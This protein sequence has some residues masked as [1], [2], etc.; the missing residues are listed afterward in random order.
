VIRDSAGNLY[1]TA[2]GGGAFGIGVINMLTPNG[3]LTVLYSFGGGLDGDNPSSGVIRTADLAER[4]ERVIDDALELA[5]LGGHTVPATKIA[6]R[7]YAS[8][9]E[10][11]EEI[12]ET[13]MLER[14]TWL[15]LRRRS[16]R[17]TEAHHYTQLWLPEFPHEPKM[18][19]MPNARS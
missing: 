2:G 1:G 5:D 7:I 19:Y 8:E 15:L 17:W 4:I 9:S 11:M 3:Q 14:L 6:Q 13:W 10:L 12:R 18:I 16:H